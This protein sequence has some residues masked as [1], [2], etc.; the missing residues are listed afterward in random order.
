[1]NLEC[2]TNTSFFNQ[3]ALWIVHINILNTKSQSVVGKVKLNQ[4]RLEDA[5]G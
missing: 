5:T 1:M 2:S 4:D 3:Q